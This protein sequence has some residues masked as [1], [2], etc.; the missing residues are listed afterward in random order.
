LSER[1]E[2]LAG[3]RGVE[4]HVEIGLWPMSRWRCG[5]PA[6]SRRR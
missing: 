3:R 4:K 6:R 2:A 1:A 5:N